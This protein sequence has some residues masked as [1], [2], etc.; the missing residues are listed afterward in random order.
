MTRINVVPVDELCD[1]HLLAEHRELTRIPNCIVKGRYNLSNQPKDYVLGQGHVKFFYTRLSYLRTRY[2]QL[3]NECTK[4]GF[5]VVYKWPDGVLPPE[6][7]F[8]N[9]YKPTDNALQIN[10]ERIQIR[11]PKKAR[12]YSK[13]I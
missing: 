4:R 8:W 5:D 3:H 10:R 2:V 13:P 6:Q 11:K 9:D 1:Q 7:K 12:Y